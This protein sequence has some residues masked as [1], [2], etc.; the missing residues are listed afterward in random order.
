MRVFLEIGKLKL[1]AYGRSSSPASLS[2]V[3]Y[4]ARWLHQVACCLVA[5]MR[6]LVA[7]VGLSGHRSMQTEVYSTCCQSRRHRTIKTIAWELT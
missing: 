5:A 6:S 2:L 4:R 1:C 3:E 7:Y